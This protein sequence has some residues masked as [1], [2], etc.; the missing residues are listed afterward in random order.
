MYFLHPIMLWLQG[1]WPGYVRPCACVPAG[2]EATESAQ[3]LYLKV[4][5]GCGKAGE[6]SS[7]GNEPL[8]QIW[9]FLP[10]MPMDHTA[11]KVFT[12]WVYLCQETQRTSRSLTSI[13]LRLRPTYSGRKGET[14]AELSS[15]LFLLHPSLL[16]F[17]HPP[18]PTSALCLFNSPLPY[19]FL[20]SSV[21]HPSPV[22]G[23]MFSWLG[24]GVPVC[25]HSCKC[26][27]ESIY[28]NLCY[29][30]LP[31]EKNWAIQWRNFEILFFKKIY[32]ATESLWLLLFIFP[33]P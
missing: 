9:V 28:L 22:T 8:G 5:W 12:C 1:T 11:E 20:V 24:R 16:L 17:D 27:L 15:F 29:F 18:L 33:Y 7:L 32:T 2:W 26:I 25:M 14:S 13:S 30:L 10:G 23:S 21:G 31:S 4:L 3:M 19:L 6:V